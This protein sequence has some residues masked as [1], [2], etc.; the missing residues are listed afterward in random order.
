[1]FS[2]DEVSPD[3]HD[4]NRRVL[5]SKVV[6][7]EVYCYCRSPNDRNEMVQCARAEKDVRKGFTYS[8]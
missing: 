1:M 7:I 3:C 4:R 5:Q 2:N 6:K 8:V